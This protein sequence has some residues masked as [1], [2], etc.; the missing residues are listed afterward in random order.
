MFL[1]LICAPALAEPGE[2]LSLVNGSRAEQG[3]PELETDAVLQAA[4]EAH[5]EDMLAREYY[6]HT[7]PE[8]EDVRDRVLA[9]GGSRWSVVAENIARC[10]G[11]G[12]PDE[13]AQVRAFH[14]GW[15]QSPGHRANILGQGLDTFGFAMTSDGDTIYAVQTFSG[16]GTP[17]GHDGADEPT[18]AVPEEV[19]AA[20]LE[21]LNAERDGQGRSPLASDA[22]LDT[23]AERL[24]EGATFSDDDMVLPDDVFG[25]LPDESE[26][27]TS[28][29]V[30]SEACG[31]C[32]A[33]A[34]RSD[35]AYFAPRLASGGEDQIFT[36]MGFA[37]V[38]NAE[39]RKVAVAVYGAK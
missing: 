27:W 24:A 38:A 5:A 32:G 33:K 37:L 26:G 15:M 34:V 28:L 6:S 35:G 18:A 21:A 7:S 29:S 19:R 20:A 36:H 8:G 4:A 30:A 13:A 11:C 1:C 22:G 16:P 2:A 31:G 39:G 3:L 14:D 17:P 10:E 12:T 25:L 23:L 9:A